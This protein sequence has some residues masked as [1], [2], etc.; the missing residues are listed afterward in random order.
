MQPYQIKYIENVR[1]IRELNDFF[2]VPATDFPSWYEARSSAHREALQLRAENDRLLTEN[3]FPTLDELTG[4]SE[5]T[6]ADLTAFAAELMDWSTNL[7]T[8]VYVL[9]H[10]AFL[11]IARLQKDR[12]AIIRELYLLGMGLYYQNR[13]LTGIGSRDAQSFSVEDELLFTEGGSYLKYFPEI[14]SE[15]IKGYII[16]S[17]ANISIATLDRRKKI[18]VTA[19]VS[20][21]VLRPV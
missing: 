9:I 5:D 21:G 6:I 11:R 8:G 7:D 15:E 4:A 10:D 19:R 3:L 12:N 1:Q 14:D 16:R 17:L 13:P 2:A 20:N 18:A